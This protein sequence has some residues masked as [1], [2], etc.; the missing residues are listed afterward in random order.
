MMVS[1]GQAS[2]PVEPLSPLEL[3]KHGSLY[4]TRPNLA[5]YIL[6]RQELDRRARE[7]FEMIQEDRLKVHIGGIYPLAD[8]AQAHD[9]LANRRTTGKLLLRI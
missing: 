2:G 9:D 8:A 5:H 7:V 3:S 4:L 1:F 6:S